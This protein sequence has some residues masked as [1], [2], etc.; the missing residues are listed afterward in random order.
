MSPDELGQY[1]ISEQSQFKDEVW[2]FANPTPGATKSRSRLN[3]GMELFDGSQ[4]TDVR[5]AQRLNWAKILVLTLLVLP[6]DG[7][8]PAPG[9]MGGFQN[10]FKWLLSW[11]SEAGYHQPHEL[12]P[13]VIRHYLDQLPL[14]IM[15]QTGETEIGIAIA[16]RAL[17][18]IMQLWDQRLALAKMGVALSTGHP[19]EGR[20]V[21]SV[22]NSIATKALGW[23]KPLPDEVAIPLL[24]KA[25]WLLGTPADDVLRL[26][27]V[28]RDPLA[29]SIIKVER[30]RGTSNCKAGIG[31]SAR[32]ERARD[33]LDD[34]EFSAALGS[35]EPWHVPLD[36]AYGQSPGRNQARMSRVRQLWES[37]RDAASIIILATTGMRV[38]E[39]LGIRAG[40]DEPTGLPNDVRLEVSIT[41]LYEWFVIRSQLSK[42]EEGL[43]REVDWVLGMR[44]LG[45]VEIP[46]AVRALY[47]LDR[48]HKPWR[49]LARTD[50]LILASMNGETL[51]LTT[52]RHNAMTSDRV[53]AS[54][55]RFIERWLDLAC[56]PDTSSRKTEENDLVLWRESKGAVFSTHMLRK[57]WAQFALA[58]DSRLLPAIQMQ[59]H[60]LSLAMTEGGYI[61]RNPL[62]LD[63]LDSMCTQKTNLAVF[64]I[65]VGKNKLAGRMGEQLE[66]ALAKMRVEVGELPTS[67]KWRQTVEWVERNDLKMFFTAHA[68][69][70][71]TRTSEMRCHDASNTPVWLRRAPNTATREPS[72]CAGCACAIMDKSHEPFWSNR[73]VDCE[74]SVRQA[75]AAGAHSGQFREIRFR[76][77][78]ARGILKRFGANLDALDA[79][80]VSIMENGHAQT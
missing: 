14:Y 51:H 58:C 35:T 3:W 17:T 68:T 21:R 37:I 53:N 72:V 48:L 79:R 36:P 20:G 10:Q 43:P 2:F 9:S 31:R 57:A 47:I 59:F 16:R 19:F 22:A 6:S 25:A 49:A 41:G 66:Q 69:C 46:L 33:F 5:H 12:T 32:K 15:A 23:I 30:K 24:N 78:Q 76:A 11:M 8:M 18:T 13:T 50:R 64:D 45:S 71:P 77:E 55:R 34:F 67:E 28:V 40:I 80:V 70:C 27:D 65:I 52:T 54:I 26:L 42:P 29:G 7:R 75:T 63:E 44:P 60:H 38:S 61:G 39:L 62:L 4:L 74:V 1:R 56:L 73:Y